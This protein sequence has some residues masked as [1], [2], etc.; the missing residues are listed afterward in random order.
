MSVF[1]LLVNCCAGT[2]PTPVVDKELLVMAEGKVNLSQLYVTV[3]LNVVVGVYPAKVILLHSPMG[4]I[5]DDNRGLGN[6]VITKVCVSPLQKPPATA[7]TEIFGV[8]EIVEL[9]LLDKATFVAVKAVKLP[10]PLT[11]RPIPVFELVQSK[12]V[13]ETVPVKPA[14][15]TGTLLQVNILVRVPT[16]GSGAMLILISVGTPSTPLPIVVFIGN[17][18]P[19]MVLK[20][21]VLLLGIEAIFIDPLGEAERAVE[22]T[23]VKSVAQSIL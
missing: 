9:I 3:S 21:V 13:P 7:G 12:S 15:L 5:D 6:T 11:P 1:E 10:V 17:K 23:S 20:S 19:V 4:V 22:F 8:T 16:T 14:A 18:V 2:E